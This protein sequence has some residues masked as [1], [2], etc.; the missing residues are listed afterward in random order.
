MI[1]ILILFLVT[2]TK[3]QITKI[4]AP[5]NMKNYNLSEKN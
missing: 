2:V 5:K 4:L 1:E 3:S